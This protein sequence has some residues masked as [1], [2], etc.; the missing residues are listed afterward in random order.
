VADRHQQLRHLAMNDETCISS[1][2]GLRLDS[3]EGSSLDARTHSLL[4]IGALV[5]ADAASASYQWAVE[6]ALAGGAT[7]DEIMATLVAVAPVAG[8]ARVVSAAPEIAIALGYPVEAALEQ[9]EGPKE[10]SPQ[11]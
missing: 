5:V 8:M 3:H 7:D 2:L 1:L 11:T 4:R 9:L 6:T 10:T